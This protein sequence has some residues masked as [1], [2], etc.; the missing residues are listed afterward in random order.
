MLQGRSWEKVE[1]YKWFELL[2]YTKNQGYGCHPIRGG[3]LQNLDRRPYL[4]DEWDGTR[5]TVIKRK[6]RH[7]HSLKWKKENRAKPRHVEEYQQM[8]VAHDRK[9]RDPTLTVGQW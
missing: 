2:A 3:A 5:V 9:T 7:W 8:L 4:K 6:E 1:D